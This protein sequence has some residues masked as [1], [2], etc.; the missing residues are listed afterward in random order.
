MNYLT[1]HLLEAIEINKE[2][3][4]LYAKIS[5][6]RSLKI[7]KILIFFE[8]L[9]LVS[10]YILDNIAKYWQKR[11]VPIM[12]HEFIPMDQT[13]EFQEKFS[14]M[15]DICSELPE[16]NTQKIQK[17]SLEYYKKKDYQGLFEYLDQII[18]V[19]MS[20]YPKHFC[21]IRHILES[22][23]RSAFLIE[24]HIQRA[25]EMKVI[26]PEFFCRYVLKNQIIIIHSSRLIDQ[27]AYP[28]QKEGIPIVYQDVPH[29]PEKVDNY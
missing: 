29:I 14:E 22:V 10:S 1:Q 11:N 20:K 12:V 27:W 16:L 26:S 4:K 28:L 13:P 24:R 25:K 15:D 9:S 2:R 3:K 8:K 17:T 18:E 6:N 21:M 7:S 19:E 23:R 5:N